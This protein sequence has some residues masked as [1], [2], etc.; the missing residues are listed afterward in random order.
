MHPLAAVLGYSGVQHLKESEAVDWQGILTRCEDY[1]RS[2]QRGRV[3]EIRKI[4][5]IFRRGS[6]PAAV[7]RS[8]L[9]RGLMC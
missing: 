4:S 6:G 8:S 1:L 7:G 9:A 5:V 2:K 3:I